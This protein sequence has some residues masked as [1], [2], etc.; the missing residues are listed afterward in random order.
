MKKTLINEIKSRL[1]FMSPIES[2]IAR[3]I[4]NDPARF[5]TYSLSELARASGVSQ[6]SIINFSRKY[7]LGGF[8]ELKL[9]V[10][11]AIHDVNGEK[12]EI[13]SDGILDSTVANIIGALENTAAVNDEQTLHQVADMIM[14]A[15]KVE[16]Y[17]IYSSAAVA[18]H[19]Y[20]QLLPLGVPANFVSDVL[21][22]AISASLLTHDS[23]V[24]AISSSGQTQD[25]IDAVR[26][27]KSNGVPVVAIT[28]HSS[29]LLASLS[30]KVLIA[31]PSGESSGMASYEIRHSQLALTDTLCRCIRD[32]KSNEETLS[33]M[34][35]ILNSHLIKD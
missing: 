29:S 6:G 27:A 16:I 25:I 24:I 5:T 23:L 14:S 22:C 1:E 7:A 26:I 2:R 20:Y 3:M 17:G 34:D 10:A 21:T 32:H 4:L 35:S 13:S 12:G 31:P 18:T 8:P 15:R 28:G 19:F 11:A 9:K 30:D 33:S